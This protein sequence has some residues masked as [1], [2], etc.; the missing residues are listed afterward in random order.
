MLSPLQPHPEIHEQRLLV[1]A[2][3]MG[4]E[5]FLRIDNLTY[6]DHDVVG[7]HQDKMLT[8][9]DPDVSAGQTGAPKTGI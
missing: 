9:F 3:P 6:Y 8:F 7:L 5:G 2:T 4:S 1:C